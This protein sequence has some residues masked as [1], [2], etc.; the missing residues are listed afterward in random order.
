MRLRLEVGSEEY[1][2]LVNS[3]IHDD[4]MDI[5][6]LKMDSDSGLLCVTLWQQPNQGAGRVWGPIT[7]ATRAK[8]HLGRLTF[9][10]VRAYELVDT[11]RVGLYDVNRLRY[12]QRTCTIIVETGIP[13]VFRVQVDTVVVVVEFE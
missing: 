4:L 11:Q 10:H 7:D 1:L 9:R 13:L 2:H 6:T 8:V 5:D 3:A 12:D